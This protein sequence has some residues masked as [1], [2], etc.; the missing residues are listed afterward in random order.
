MARIFDVTCCLPFFDF[1]E[2]KKFDQKFFMTDASKNKFLGCGG[3]NDDQWFIMQWDEDFIVNQN[4]SI[5]F[6][7]LYALTVGILG[8][9][10]TYR[11]QQITIF[12]DNQSVVYMVNKLTSGC[13]NCMT[14]IRLIVLHCLQNNVKLNVQYIESKANIFADYLSRLKYKQFW[15]EAQRQKRIFKKKSTEIP[16]ILIPVDKFWLGRNKDKKLDSLPV[17]AEKLTEEQ[18]L[19]AH[20]AKNEGKV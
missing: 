5:N 1:E 15:Q 7:E 4:P 18:E 9:L 14:L 17:E 3:I 10:H 8:W 13:K 20:F 2:N 19:S 6:L 11:N 12:C 16:E